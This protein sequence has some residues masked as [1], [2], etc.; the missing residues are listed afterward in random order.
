MKTSITLFVLM[1][2]FI[3]IALVIAF[4]YI[5]N[6]D[7][8]SGIKGI[9]SLELSLPINTRDLREI[10]HGMLPFCT[11]YLTFELRE[12]APV[13]AVIDAYVSEI[14]DGV[15]TL[16]P[17][18]GIEIRYSPM[19]NTEVRE[20][21]YVIQGN[22]LGI[23]DSNLLEFSVVN[24]SDDVYECPYLYFSE[25]DRAALLNKYDIDFCG[26]N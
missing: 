24:T 3:L 17:R 4:V 6:L 1:G 15:I 25:E 14:K 10:E 16:E 8:S 12:E 21:E 20:G 26:C 7:K 18:P 11:E 2:I 23:L 13:L 19:S 22:T 9:E 5:P